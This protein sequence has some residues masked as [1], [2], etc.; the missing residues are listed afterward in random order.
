MERELQMSL[1]REECENTLESYEEE[2]NYLNAVIDVMA[3]DLA[4]ASEL[5]DKEEVKNRYS[6]YGTERLSSLIDENKRLSSQVI[7]ANRVAKNYKEHNIELKNYIAQIEREF[8]DNPPL[9]FEELKENMWVWDNY[10]KKYRKIFYVD[11]ETKKIV[12]CGQKLQV[13]YKEG[14]FYEREVKL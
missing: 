1:T 7:E 9:N 3:D 11:A 12:F 8:K 4:K 2:I 5:F 6:Y 13:N 14:R 10:T